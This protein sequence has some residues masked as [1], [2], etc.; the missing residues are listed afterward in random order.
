MLRDLLVVG[1][2]GV[3]S[4]GSALAQ[5]CPCSGGSLLNQTQLAS[6]LGNNT[7]CAV[8]GTESWQEWHGPTS[9][10]NFFELGEN[11]ANPPAS[12]IWSIIGTGSN[13][14]V[15]YNYGTGGTWAYAACQEGANVHFC[16][17]TPGGRNVTNATVKIGKASCG[18]PAP[19][20]GRR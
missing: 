11:F 9:G 12:G 14:T 2:L 20:T 10:S 4:A 16:T 13:T 7:V 5:S 18:A 8:L 1:L 17:A 6:L 15:S 19:A 3:A